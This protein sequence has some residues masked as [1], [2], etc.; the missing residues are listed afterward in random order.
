MLQRLPDSVIMINV[1]DEW[2]KENQN[3]EIL[4]IVN[5]NGVSG[6]G[7]FYKEKEVTNG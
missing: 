7:I 6:F 4:H 3:I 1:I 5:M 2:V